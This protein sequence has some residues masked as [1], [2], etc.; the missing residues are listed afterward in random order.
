VLDQAATAARDYRLQ[1]FFTMLA[2]ARQRAA[3]VAP[4]Q[5][6]VVD[7]VGSKDCRQFA[8]LTGQWNFPALLQRIVEGPKRQMASRVF[9]GLGLPVGAEWK[10]LL[11]MCVE[12]TTE[13]A[14]R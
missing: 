12:L 3:L 13:R 4:H 2:Q 11:I 6:G 10:V 9:I 8:L 14:A 7:N 1:A 5:A